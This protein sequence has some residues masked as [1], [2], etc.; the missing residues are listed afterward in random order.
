VSLA[1]LEEINGGTRLGRECSTLGA[2]AASGVPAVR[3]PKLARVGIVLACSRV[4]ARDSSDSGLSDV[5]QKG[6]VCMLSRSAVY[7]SAVA[8]PGG[9]WE[10]NTSQKGTTS[11][12]YYARP[13]GVPEADFSRDRPARRRPRARGGHFF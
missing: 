7:G 2:P 9:V 5:A 10:P 8:S 3:V 1:F 12:Y 13:S 4:Y 6:G 11:F